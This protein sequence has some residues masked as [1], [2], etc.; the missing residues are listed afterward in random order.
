MAPTITGQVVTLYTAAIVVNPYETNAAIRVADGSTGAVLSTAVVTVNDVAL[1]YSTADQDNE[2]PLTLA[3]GAA[4]TVKVSVNGATYTASGTSSSTFPSITAP[5]SGI[6][7]SGGIDNMVAWTGAL[8]DNTAEYAVGIETTSGTLVYPSTGYLL[9]AGAT[10]TSTTVPAD[11]LANG[12]Y[13]VVVGIVDLL[14]FPGAGPNSE[15]A[16]GGFAYASVSVVSG[17]PPSLSSVAIAPSAVAVSTGKT[18]QLAA[19]ATFSDGSTQ[20]VTTQATWSSANTSTL[21]VSSGG[22]ITGVAPGNA[23]VSAQY[24]GQ[25]AGLTA[26][27]Y[28]LNLSPVPPLSQTVTYQG[29]YAHSGRITFGASGPSFPP[30]GHWSVTLGGT[31]TS[32]P[33]IAGGM[34]FVTTDLSPTGQATGN[35]LYALDETTGSIVWGPA[36]AAAITG[37]SAIA[38]D[39]G[40][41]FVTGDYGVRSFDAATGT[42]GWANYQL[43]AYPLES[44]PTAVNGILYVNTEDVLFALDEVSGSTLWLTGAAGATSGAPAVS[45]DGVFT[46]LQCAA[47]KLDLFSGLVLWHFQTDCSSASGITPA[48]ANNSLYARGIS[49][50]TNGPQNRQLNAATGAQQATFL[51]DAIPAF[52]DTAGFFLS[53]GTLTASS[54]SS[55]STLWTFTGDGHLISAPLVIDSVVVI[56]S[57]SGM[58]Y[59]L[60]TA[61]GAVLW[62]D[63]AGGPIAAPDAVSAPPSGIGAGEGY[64]VVPAGNVVS[65]WRLIPSAAQSSA[66]RT[67][68]ARR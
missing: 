37:F 20:D 59:A 41:L 34:V 43:T 17:P 12:S 52:S 15:L 24:D 48:Y 38:Y 64:L 45:S 26:T 54:L 62:S 1:P 3:A 9:T 14:S 61:S 55:G 39:H 36:T 46:A 22:L 32:Y 19:V 49:D 25:T 18:L 67:V 16:F 44:I 10:Q 11:T 42:P 31:L 66:R 27:V 65:A 13:D 8:P 23:A 7:W 33:I 63:T 6:S 60:D 53:G 28:T 58:V 50:T 4:V 2:G 56:A 51:A 40:T 30:A 57:S 68:R 21:T 35:S 5:M 47:Y 29:D